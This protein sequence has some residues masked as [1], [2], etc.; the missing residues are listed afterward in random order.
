VPY[1]L[2]KW[3]HVLAAITAVGANIT[4]GIWIAR[5]SRRPEVLPFTLRGIKLIDDRVANPAYGLLLI[6]GLLMVLTGN[7][8]LTTPWL[9]IALI[10][11]V[12]LLLVGLL[13]FTPT[14]R[15]QI[16]VL[17]AEGASSP[18]YQ[19]VAR[20]GTILGIVLVVLGVVIVF[21]MVVKPG[22]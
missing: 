21:M 1:L 9:L 12:I 19:A 8:N 4:Y 16:R 18:A 5:A 6:T 3:L 20:L 7:L 17:E 10:L 2:L 15:N 22:A 14:L 11:Y 13:G